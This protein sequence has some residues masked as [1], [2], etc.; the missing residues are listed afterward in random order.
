MIS[1]CRESFF[2]EADEFW[3]FGDD[4]FANC[5]WYR[6]FFPPVTEEAETTTTTTTEAKQTAVDTKNEVTETI[7]AKQLAEAE[8]LA[9]KLPDV[10]TTEPAV[11]EGSSNKKQK[12]D[13]A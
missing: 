3:G 7:Q 1:S 4:K 8:D 2:Y 11:E 13:D 6:M 10:P 9:A 12:R 5:E